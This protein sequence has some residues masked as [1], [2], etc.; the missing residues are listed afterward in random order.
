MLKNTMIK[1]RLIFVIGFLSLLMILIGGLGLTSLTGVNES[2]RT[3]YED[4]LI[5]VG[6][7]DSVIRGMNRNQLAIASAISGDPTKVS[8][9]ALDVDKT[10]LEINK[11]WDG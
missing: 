3:V 11:L 4:R 1:S 2:L 9:I 7:L 8:S 10:R 6:Q 5:A